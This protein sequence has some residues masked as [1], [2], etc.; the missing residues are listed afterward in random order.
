MEDMN[1]SGGKSWLALRESTFVNLCKRWGAGLSNPALIAAFGWVQAY[2]SVTLAAID[3]FLSAREIYHAIKTAKNRLTKDE[4]KEA[5]KSAMRDFANTSIR[6]NKL[7]TEEQ[8]REYG[9]HTPKPG[10]PIPRPEIYP[11]AEVAYPGAHLLALINIH[12][13]EASEDDPR[14]GAGV[15]IFWGVLGEPTAADRF[16]LASPPAVGFDLPHSTFTRRRRHR[17]DFEGDSGKTVWFGL[18]YENGKDGKAGEGPF[19]PLFSAFVP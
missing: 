14:S 1:M 7:M 10:S 11:T 16:R 2:V 12:P 5:A 13:S 3:A 17:F 6:Y 19:G 15:R 4:A 8:K 9:I 18:R